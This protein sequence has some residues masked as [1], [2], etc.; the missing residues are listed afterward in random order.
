VAAGAG[1]VALPGLAAVASASGTTGF[2]VNA[3]SPITIASTSEDCQSYVVGAST[4]KVTLDTNSIFHSSAG[5]DYTLTLDP[6]A[7]S[8]Y[9][10]RV[11][12][13]AEDKTG[14]VLSTLG[15]AEFDGIPAGG[16]FDFTYT[17]PSR[18]PD[19]STQVCAVAKTQ[20]PVNGGGAD[21]KSNVECQDI[22]DPVQPTPSAGEIGLSESGPQ[23]A[24]VGDTVTYTF[25]VTNPGSVALTGVSLSDPEC[26]AAPSPAGDYP[27]TMEPG[28]TYTYTCTHVVT[29]GDHDPLVDT[30]TVTGTD[31]SGTTVTATADHS[32]TI[33]H[34]AI[35]LTKTVSPAS[36][37]P[38][39]SVTYT[40]VV[41]N[42]GDIVLSP[43]TITDDQLGTVAVLAGLEPGVSRTVTKASSIGT[44]ATTAAAIATGTDPL[45][46]KVTATATTTTTPVLGSA[47]QPPK[48]PGPSTT[49][50]EGSP[51]TATPDSPKA[52]NPDS[53]PVA[54]PAATTAPAAAN[55]PRSAL[56]FTGA[57]TAPS[58]LAGGLAI[59][60]GAALV[61]LSRRRR[62]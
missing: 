21:R 48:G 8:T 11:C 22:A 26:A 3:G 38:G 34:P 56:A 29:A 5:V 58:L 49:A 4:P 40:F 46:R 30:S 7:T 31:P 27:S 2:G 52:A 23:Y 33:I 17:L 10:T 53:S 41:E 6:P 15:E 39:T 51:K 18:F 55:V 32:V 19:G 44:T 60:V 14:T 1:L 9:N 35:A 62:S 47:G 20:E 13:V 24:H 25:T 42:T 37:A 28:A 16:G 12:V 43:V 61:L 36:G 45:G 50:S 57:D 54:V 59:A